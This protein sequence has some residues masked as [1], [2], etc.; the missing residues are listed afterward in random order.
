MMQRFGYNLLLSGLCGLL[1]VGQ[2][3]EAWAQP[4]PTDSAAQ[5]QMLQLQQQ[6]VA[7]GEARQ[8]GDARLAAR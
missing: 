6:M 2:A 7:T 1:W 5:A 8:N 3:T 4:A